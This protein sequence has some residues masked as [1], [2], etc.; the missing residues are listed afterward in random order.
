M[1]MN[2]ISDYDDEGSPGDA[3]MYYE[4][5]RSLNWHVRRFIRQVPKNQLVEFR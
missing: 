5:A 3:R 2:Y 1:P 4:H